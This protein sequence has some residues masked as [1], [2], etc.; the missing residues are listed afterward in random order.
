MKDKCNPEWEEMFANED[1]HKE[2]ISETY[3][4]LI[5]LNI[6][7]T[8]N[9]RHKWAKHRNGYFLEEDMGIVIRH[10]RTCS[11]SLILTQR[12]IKSLM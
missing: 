2:F 8:N 3:R 1:T 9:P 5:Q 6:K 7:D 11:A 12:Q 10:M 4:Q